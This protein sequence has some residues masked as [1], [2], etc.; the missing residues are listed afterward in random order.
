MI[1][2]RKNFSVQVYDFEDEVLVGLKEEWNH[3]TVPIV[4]MG[5]DLIGGYTELTEH[6]NGTKAHQTDNK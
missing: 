1:E 3:P 5:R 4:S 2:N 6:F